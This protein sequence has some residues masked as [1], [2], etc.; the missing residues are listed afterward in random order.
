M[1][2]LNIADLVVQ[3]IRNLQ[4]EHGAAEVDKVGT[5]RGGSSGIL[6][7][8]ETGEVTAGVCVRKAHLR[9]IGV[10]VNKYEQAKGQ[11]GS[12]EHMFAAGR[13]NEDSWVEQLTKSWPGIV[14][15]EADVPVTWK[16][17]DD[18]TV[19]GRPDVVLAEQ[20]MGEDEYNPALQV[21]VTGKLVH[22]LELK[23]ASSFWT[24]RDLLSKREP[25]LEHVIQAALYMWRLSEQEGY[26][27]PFS[28]ASALR[29]NYWVPSAP[30][31]LNLPMPGEPG[32]EFI[33]YKLQP[34]YEYD[35]LEPAVK[36]T[37]REM[38][39]S[40]KLGKPKE[41]TRVPAVVQKRK[42][43]EEVLPFQILPFV[44]VFDLRFSG[45]GM[46]DPVQFDVHGEGQ[47]KDTPVTRRRIQDFYLRTADLAKSEVLP[48][49][50]MS[51][52]AQ[53]EKN[54]NWTICDYCPLRVHCR[55]TEAQG[56]D[57]WLEP[58]RN[59]T[60]A[61]PEPVPGAK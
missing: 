20:E 42:V 2:H 53:G 59:G 32:S 24:V 41:I 39:K 11:E 31:P 60:L 37:V 50:P 51:L 55:A 12:K 44:I 43:G 1:A 3:G 56:Y 46:D 17:R 22:G 25:K 23:L 8:D 34:K 15:R 26:T 45:P 61:L 49:A 52:T 10:D 57:A 28:V 58:I 54:K 30:F 7:A 36:E 18:L 16:I 6:S 40:G 19:T 9:F 4:A 47:W 38:G 21:P 29:N 14:L 13:T 5:L 33:E 35:E 27:V 48:P